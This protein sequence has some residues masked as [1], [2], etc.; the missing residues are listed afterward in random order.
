MPTVATATGEH[1]LKGETHEVEGDFTWSRHSVTSTLPKKMG[2][3]ICKKNC[4]FWEKEAIA[5]CPT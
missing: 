2:F 1:G 5:V 4:V 3:F